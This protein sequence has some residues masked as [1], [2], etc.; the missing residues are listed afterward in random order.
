[1]GYT[2]IMEN[3]QRFFRVYN[4][5]FSVG[6]LGSMITIQTIFDLVP[7]CWKHVTCYGS[8]NVPYADF[9][10]LKV[11]DLNLVDNVLHITP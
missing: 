8:H 7:L 3:Y 11:V 10:M 9:Q 5:N 1:M 4:L 6:S 2:I